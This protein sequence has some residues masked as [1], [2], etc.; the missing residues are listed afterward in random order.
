MS[1]LFGRYSFGE[2]QNQIGIGGAVC[3][4]DALCDVEFPCQFNLGRRTS[5]SAESIDPVT[6][7]QKLGNSRRPCLHK[8]DPTT[9][10]W[11]RD[12]LLKTFMFRGLNPDLIEQVLSASVPRCEKKDTKIITEGDEGNYFYIVAEGFVEYIIK[13][14][15]VNRSGPGSFFGELALLYNAPRAATVVATTDVKLFVLDRV[16]VKSIL[17]QQ[18]AAK[19]EHSRKVLASVDVLHDLPPTCQLR[20]ADALQPVKYEANSVV[21]KEGDPGDCFY[22]IDEGEVEITS[23]GKVLNR[24]GASDYFGELA[25]INDEPRNATVTAVTKLNLERLDKWGFERLLGKDV[26]EELRKRDPT[27]RHTA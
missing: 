2:S 25:L 11:L 20:L 6:L 16:T 1:D 23:N 7:S 10:S 15:K 12:L 3:S 18:L 8:L 22:L 4:Q 5:V 21:I 13:G 9:K 17:V 14:E 26:V 27:K 24:L 19:R